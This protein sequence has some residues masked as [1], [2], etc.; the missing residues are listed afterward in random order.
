VEI[1]N[2]IPLAA[3]AVWSVLGELQ[4][5]LAVVFG[6]GMVIFFHELGHFAVAKWCNVHVERFSIGIGPIIWS[7]QRG[8]TEYALS[9]LPLGGYVKMLGQDDMDPNQMTSSEIAEN[10]RSYSSKTVPQRMAIISAGVLMNVATGFLFFAIGYWNGVLEPAPVVG[11]VRAGFP[12][13]EAGLRAGDRVTA[14]NEEPIRSFVDLQEAILLSSGDLKI[15]VDRGGKALPN[16]IVLTPVKASPGRSIGVIPAVTTEIGQIDDP[17]RIADA[18]MAIEK[19]SEAFLPGDRIVGLQPQ[20]ESLDAAGEQIP[21][22]PVRLIADLRRVLAT[23]A[24]REMV[25]LVERKSAD[26]KPTVV[27]IRVPRQPVRKLGF[28]MAMGP[29][30]AIQSNSPAAQ[31]GLKVGDTIRAVDGLKPGEDIDPLS[32]PVYFGRNGGQT[33]TVMYSRATSGGTVEG[34]CE[35]VPNA[36]LPGWMESPD[37][38]TSPLTIPSIGLGY[39]VQNYI[40]KILPGSEVEKLGGLSQLTKITKIELLHREPGT[41]KPDAWGNAE[42]PVELPLAAG[43]NATAE[44]AEPNWAWAFDQLQRAPGRKLVLHF[45]DGK[46]TGTRTLQELELEDDWFLWVRGFNPEIWENERVLLRAQSLPE[47]LTLGLATT[48]KVAF[49]IYRSLRKMVGREVDMESLSGPVGI[50]KIA[51]KVAERGFVELLVF[52]GILSINLAILNFLPIPILDGGHMVFLLW[53]GITRRKPSITVINW[54]HA[55]GMVFLLSLLVF[56]MWIDFFVS[57]N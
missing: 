38:S 37:S 57:G 44:E 25:Y 49:S 14:V 18:G 32:L 46:T 23:Y 54:A 10:P 34:Q 30:R 56:V 4:T 15:N 28:W 3:G 45:E 11:G 55:A 19:A 8:E 7:H 5:I 52:L 43:E 21:E 53:E 2:Y 33:V 36:D 27:R 22:Q 51:Y 42:T 12:A 1:L 17:V 24:D 48:R 13:W 41:G 31:A 40:A 20:G 47:A 16:P 50:A 35:L 9:V 6:L 26:G 29:I 39:Q